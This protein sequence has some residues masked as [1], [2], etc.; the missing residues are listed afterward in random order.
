MPLIANVKTI[1][2]AATEEGE[3]ERSAALAY[4]LSLA[5]AADARLVVHSASVP[6]DLPHGRGGA[7]A[8]GL[9]AAEN[10]RLRAL[11]EQVAD[12]VR[13]G[14][15]L[16]GVACVTE[17]PQLPY[18]ELR[19]RLLAQ[20]RVSDLVLLDADASVLSV[21]GGLLRALIFAGGRPAIVVPR[22]VDAFACRTVLVAWDGSEPASRAVAGAL[23]LLR[24]AETVEIVCYVGEKDLSRSASG[25][26]LTVA[27]GRHGVNA[28]V[29]ELPAGDD[30][31]ASLRDQAGLVRADLIVM[32]AF[33][34][35]SLLEW[36]F[37]GVTQRML[38]ESP[39]PLL[40]AH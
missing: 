40:L 9:I 19:D 33:A 38:S 26:D 25:A 28:V 12:E 16:G 32:G 24:A 21:D 10:K 31:G 18:A 8:G 30:V 29:K 1:L 37:G 3:G 36:L 20:A 14:A 27:L 6:L 23:P 34:R 5:A 4:G 15:A 13:R 39:V 17:A 22:G 7:T 2:V 35:S 11:T